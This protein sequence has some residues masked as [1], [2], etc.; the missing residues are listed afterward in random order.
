L[1]FATAFGEGTKTEKEKSMSNENNNRVLTRMGARQL[2]QNEIEQVTGARIS[3]LL[4][5]I[6]THSATG[7]VDERLDE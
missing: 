6:I 2:T 7:A 4:S 1:I 3:S 5:V